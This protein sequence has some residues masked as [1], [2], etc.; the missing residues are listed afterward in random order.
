MVSPIIGLKATSEILPIVWL[1]G[2]Y[3]EFSPLSTFTM[4]K[5]LLLNT[6]SLGIAKLIKGRGKISRDS[7]LDRSLDF[8]FI[9]AS[10]SLA[11]TESLLR[12]YLPKVKVG[13]VI[14]GHDFTAEFPG[15]VEAVSRV[16]DDALR[17][18]NSFVKRIA[19]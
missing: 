1:F 5:H 7:Y 18:G 13:G 4:A 9:D 10:H 14:A 12:A 16:L 17:V 15:V 19:P 8:V 6:N 2:R 3:S 11:D